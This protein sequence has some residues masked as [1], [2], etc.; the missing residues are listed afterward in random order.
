[1]ILAF[2]ISPLDIA[3]NKDIRGA[4]VRV[5]DRVLLAGN[6][7]RKLTFWAIKRARDLARETL[8]PPWETR[9]LCSARG[10][11]CRSRPLVTVSAGNLN[12]IT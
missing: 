10:N 11:R 5:R 1:M 3:R 8:A 9:C 12:I 4:A 6:D 2:L 7:A